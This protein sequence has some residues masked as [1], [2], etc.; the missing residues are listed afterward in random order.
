LHAADDC[1]A[2]AADRQLLAAKTA[3][4]YKPPPPTFARR[5]ANTGPVTRAWAA[6][7]AAVTVDAAM[8]SNSQF[9]MVEK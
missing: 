3:R 1:C 7:V 9:L 4:K 2:D 6:G 5:F 8:D